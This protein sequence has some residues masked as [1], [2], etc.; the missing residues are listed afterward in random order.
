MRKSILTLF[1]VLALV[2]ACCVNC[3]GEVKTSGAICPDRNHPHAIDLGLPS[4]TLW[5]CCN[6]GAS[7]PDEYG[8]YFAWGET[9]E[10]EVGDEQHYKYLNADGFVDIGSD[11][12][13][14][15][16]D[17]AHVKWGDDWVLPTEA[18]YQELLDNCTFTRERHENQKETVYLVT[19]PN[20]NTI[21][22]PMCDDKKCH[23]PGRI[24]RYW[25]SNI[26]PYFNGKYARIFRVDID[27]AW[28]LS[29]FERFNGISVRP[30][31]KK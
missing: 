22:F 13:G 12:S 6:I 7:K 26:Y 25:S 17:V 8:S 9:D 29:D 15:D 3:T 10:C 21:I 31:V 4:G 20:G 1:G 19:G 16:Y 28:Q 23:N 2:V 14:T 5:S 18:D 27:P 30:V 11:I 24:G